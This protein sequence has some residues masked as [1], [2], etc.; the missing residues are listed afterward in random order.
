M[1][2]NQLF[3]W[4]NF[5]HT[6][7]PLTLKDC[8][9]H[10][11]F[12]VPSHCFVVDNLNP[13]GPLSM[14]QRVKTVW[15]L[16]KDSCTFVLL[17]QP[18]S[19]FC[20]TTI[21]KRRGNTSGWKSD[22]SQVQLRVVVRCQVLAGTLFFFFHFYSLWNPISLHLTSLN[23]YVCNDDDDDSWIMVAKSTKLNEWMN[24]LDVVVVL[25]RA[26]NYVNNTLCVYG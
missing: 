15:W 18:V 26:Q 12:K 2:T 22:W 23:D 3:C 11:T 1:F 25:E 4:N 6:T 17:H 21:D 24:H 16:T 14:N 5:Q 19:F 9:R 8:T 7:Q 10:H 20:E 13:V